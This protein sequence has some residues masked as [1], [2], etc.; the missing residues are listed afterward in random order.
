[1]TKAELDFLERVFDAEI[2]GRMYQTKS[3]MAKKMEDQG[4]IIA[5]EERFGSVLGVIICKGYHLTIKG[6]FTYCTSER[7]KGEF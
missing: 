7:C 6:N 3:K 4:F 1:M 5:C 2:N